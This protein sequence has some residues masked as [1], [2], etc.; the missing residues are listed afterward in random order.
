MLT[1][2]QPKF[3]QIFKDK[4]MTVNKIL[5]K[6]Q[7]RLDILERKFSLT[8]RETNQVIFGMELI[9][10]ITMRQRVTEEDLSAFNG[11]AI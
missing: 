8:T 7:D 1:V 3:H 10:R 9:D 5:D 11:M 2:L 4:K 6:I